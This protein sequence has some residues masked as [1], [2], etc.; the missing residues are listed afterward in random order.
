MQL[1]TVLH[2]PGCGQG[3]STESC[4]QAC[5]GTTAKVREVEWEERERACVHTCKTEVEARMVLAVSTHTP[6]EYKENRLRLGLAHI[7]TVVRSA[8]TLAHAL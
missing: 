8:N 2:W 1:R 3:L 6:K 5:S 7:S 4:N